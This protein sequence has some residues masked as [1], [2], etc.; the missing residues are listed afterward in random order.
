MINKKWYGCIMAAESEN[1]FALLLTQDEYE[2]IKR[3]ILTSRQSDCSGYC[4]A[5]DITIRGYSNSQEASR[6]MYSSFGRAASNWV[7]ASLNRV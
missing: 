1:H 7:S 6:V 5:C 4:G 3:F 2:A